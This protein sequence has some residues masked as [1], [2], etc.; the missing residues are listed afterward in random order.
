MNNRLVLTKQDVRKSLYNKR[1]ENAVAHFKKTWF[2]PIFASILGHRLEST[3]LIGFAV[4]QVGAHM[5]GLPGW[6]CPIKAL[7]GFPCPGCGLTLAMDELL[8]GQWLAS[9]HTHAF[10][11]IFLAAFVLL[12]VSV[13]LPA[14]ARAALV[15]FMTRLEI[16]TGLTAWVLSL[17]MWYWCI[18]L[19]GLV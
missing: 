19:V 7:L 17:L 11:P 4:F 5:L 1:M 15:A 16:R 8:H 14:T 9:I 12:F 6:A 3:V 18:R 13:L 2:S 10:A